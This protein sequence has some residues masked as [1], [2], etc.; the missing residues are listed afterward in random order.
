MT[1]KQA[2][3]LRPYFHGLTDEQFQEEIN[4][5]P[6]NNISGGMNQFTLHIAEQ[7]VDE[8]RDKLPHRSVE[9]ASLKR[10]LSRI[11]T[12]IEE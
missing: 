12:L 1:A 2:E 10:I 4:K 8:A 6:L 5:Y 3:A 9:N 11:K 7:A